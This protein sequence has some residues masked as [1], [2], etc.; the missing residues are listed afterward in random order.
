MSIELTTD[1]RGVARL[2]LSRPEKHNALSEE[3]LVKLTEL[4]DEIAGRDDI[5][6]VILDA[7]GPTFCAGG[8]LRWMQDQIAAGPDQRRAAAMTLAGM[9]ERINTLPQP[10]IGRVQGN[11]FGG[12]VGMACVCDVTIAV[13]GARFGLTETKLGLIPATIGPYVLARMGEANARQVFMSSRIFDAEEARRLSIVS[14]VVAAEGLD[15]AI[16]AE[17][18]PYLSCAPGAVA[19]AKAQVRDLGMPITPEV[20]AASIDRLVDR[21]DG[22]EAQQGLEA[23]FAKTPPPWVQKT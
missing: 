23:F 19:A 13:E 22:T 2:T 20:V 7:V 4:G 21:W 17:V 5:R 11:A 18:V 9:L 6:V 10:V 16:E 14:Q 3:M 12:G 1:G 15:A 8:D